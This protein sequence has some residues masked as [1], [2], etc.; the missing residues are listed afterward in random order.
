MTVASVHCNIFHKP[1][2]SIYYRSNRYQCITRIS[3]ACSHSQSITTLASVLIETSR[4][5]QPPISVSIFLQNVIAPIQHGQSQPY[6]IPANSSRTNRHRPLQILT[7]RYFH[8]SNSTEAELPSLLSPFSSWWH[9]VGCV[10]S[11][12]TD[13]RRYSSPVTPP[14]SNQPKTPPTKIHRT[15]TTS[16]KAP[17]PNLQI[18]SNSLCI[19]EDCSKGFHEFGPL[20]AGKM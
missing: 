4:S 6:N 9:S 5:W 14:M 18:G 12:S 19:R 8:G 2:W 7:E 1:I 13:C 10:W 15:F 20:V 3:E 16:P 11:R 17:S